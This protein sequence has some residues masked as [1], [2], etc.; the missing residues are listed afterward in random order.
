MPKYEVARL[1]TSPNPISLSVINPGRRT[2]G[3]YFPWS[4]KWSFVFALV[5]RFTSWHTLSAGIDRL[6]RHPAKAELPKLAAT[7]I[8]G[9]WPV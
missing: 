3:G 5:V 4:G 9:K 6:P 2:W 1:I 8:P 7:E